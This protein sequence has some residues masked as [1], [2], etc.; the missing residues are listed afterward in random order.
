MVAV[1]LDGAAS[2]ER[3][4]DRTNDRPNERSIERT[5]FDFDF[6]LDFDFDSDSDFHFNLD[7]DFDFGFASDSGSDSD[8]GREL[9]ELMY[10]LLTLPSTLPEEIV[11]KAVVSNCA[12]GIDAF[13]FYCE[14]VDNT[15]S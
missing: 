6:D 8:C 3:R 7:I 15:N 13:L 2:N 12:L 14:S 1:I 10:A 11:N 9:A 5:N 4:I